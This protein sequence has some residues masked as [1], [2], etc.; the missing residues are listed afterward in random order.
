MK[1]N[2]IRKVD[3]IDEF[4]EKK[5]VFIHDSRF[6]DRTN[7]EWYEVRDLLKEYIIDYPGIL[8]AC[9]NS[10]IWN[11]NDDY[12]AYDVQIAMPICDNDK[13]I[14]WYYVYR[15]RMLFTYDINKKMYLHDIIHTK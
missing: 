15:F 2:V 3:I 12:S 11:E 6:R 13:E 1:S 7:I 4:N 10:I 9:K 8:D 14:R 5:M